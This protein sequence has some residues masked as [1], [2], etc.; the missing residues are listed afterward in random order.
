MA[1]L[2]ERLRELDWVEPPDVWSEI[3]RLGPRTPSEPAPS[4][5]RRAA[6]VFLALALSV[7]GF[8]F[9]D[10]AF[11]GSGRK[12]GQSPIPIAPTGNGVITFG[13]GYHICS[14]DPDGSGLTDL[15]EPYDRE[16]VLAA[17]SPVVSPDGTRIAFRGYPAGGGSGGANYDIYVMGA[18]G[19]NLMNLTGPNDP[20]G[21]G[22]AQWSPDGSLI[23]YEGDDGTYVMNA[24]GSDQRKLV[25][26]AYPT[27]SPDGSWI[28]F[29]MGRNPGADLWKI[30][31]D[32]TGL[33]QLTESTGWDELPVWSPDGSKIAFLRERA[34]YVVNDDGTELSLIA[35]IK[36]ADPFQPQWSPDG[37]TLAFEVEMPGTPDAEASGERNYDIFT[38]S[39]D[40]AGLSDLTPTTDIT[41]NYPIWSPD[42]TKIAFGASRM[43]SGENAGSFDLYTMNPDGTGIERLT[44]EA[45]LGVEFD[46]SWQPVT[47][48]SEVEKPTPTG[49][50]LAHGSIMFTREEP[51][52]GG[53]R[54]DL[55][56]IEPDG[57]GERALTDTPSTCEA[58]PAVAPG[59][60]TVAVSLDL[61]DI[62]VI[63]LATSAR[64]RL[65]SDSGT[66]D[67]GPAWS[68]DG[69]Q[70][71]FSRG[72]RLGPSHL[73]VMD[74]DGTDVS[75][76]TQ[77]SGSDRHAAWSPDGTR[78]A[79]ARSGNYGYEVYVMDAD[80]SNVRAVTAVTAESA[81]SPAW[82]PDGSQ[83]ALDVDGAI[84]VM[85]VD[86]TGLRRLSPEL[87]RGVLDMHASW[88]PD[89]TQIAFERYTNDDVAAAAEDGDI[90][91]VDADGTDATRVT[92]GPAIDSW[93]QWASGSAG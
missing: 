40:G 47:S 93:P 44:R 33:T 38:V 2:R 84:Y 57:T 16:L 85:S 82:S 7:G 49:G 73:Y 25:A 3:E 60:S 28:A 45:G 77:G 66:L 26:G 34:I 50:P 91:I 8:V 17:Y 51:D 80:G 70:I 9:V 1:D 20:Q 52:G 83:I 92:H 15:L 69:S 54:C 67:N 21:Q 4:L 48:A 11:R 65:T 32:G 46:I 76:L 42:G 5:V 74:A 75:R 68:P 6:V 23:A 55:F 72:P 18:D 13:C 30:H 14:V 71:A 79:F 87:P 53:W 58:L 43:L 31:P 37:T 56:T 59:G 36:D 19:S 41:E 88:S 86:G 27:W 29:V 90:W 24:D 62:A 89:G 61:D 81:P 39:A 64:R 63:D 78:I 35:D 22:Y 12:P 10:R